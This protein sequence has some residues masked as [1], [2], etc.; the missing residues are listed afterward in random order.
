[1]RGGTTPDGDGGG[2]ANGRNTHPNNTS[3]G[4]WSRSRAT[5]P[6]HFRE[7]KCAMYVAAYTETDHLGGHD[8][9]T[10]CQITRYSVINIPE[11]AGERTG[12]GDGDEQDAALAGYGGHMPRLRQPSILRPLRRPACR[13]SRRLSLAGPRSGRPP[14]TPQRC[15]TVATTTRHTGATERGR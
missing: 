13:P 6:V 12:N 8:V 7:G 4:A 10:E 9:L 14:T 2:V 11:R 15:A 3:P 5:P 1:M